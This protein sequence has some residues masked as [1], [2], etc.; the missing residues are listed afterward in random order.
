MV[1]GFSTTIGARSSPGLPFKQPFKLH[2]QR[3]F[4][5]ACWLPLTGILQALKNPRSCQQFFYHPSV[6]IRQAIASALEQKSEA[7]MVDA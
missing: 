6:H 1:A 3:I 5:R 2:R 7:L 4:S